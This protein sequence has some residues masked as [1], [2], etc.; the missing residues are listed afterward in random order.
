M[1][2][3][4]NL[5]PD[6]ERGLLAKAQ[7]K[8]ISI[9]EFVEEIVIREARNF[10]KSS[11]RTGQALLDIGARVRGLLTDEEVDSLFARNSLLNPTVDLS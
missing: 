2:I 5:N 1:V 11:D 4:L 7:S 6:I 8:G 9:S 10:E 3:S